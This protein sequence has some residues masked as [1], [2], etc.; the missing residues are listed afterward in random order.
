MATAV[1]FMHSS[2][3]SNQQVPSSTAP[4]LE[5][6]C[7]FT[8]DLRRKQKRWQDG[9][10][11]YHTFNKR[12]MVY[13]DRGN[14]VGDTHWRE[15][16]DFD[17]GE[18]VELE[19][20]GTI[21]QVAECT[22]SRDQDLSELIDKRVREKT[23]RQAAAVARRPPTVEATTPHAAVPHF[24]LR[25]KPLHHLIGTPTGHHGRA[26]ISTESPYEE[27][28]K[29]VDSPQNDGARPGKRR[30]R[31]IS[32]PSKNGYAQSL[33]G[34]TLTLSGVPAS[35]PPA[36]N[37]PS[38]KTSPILIDSQ[39]LPSS[40][41]SHHDDSIDFVPKPSRTKNLSALA[42]AQADAPRAMPSNFRAP[43]TTLARSTVRITCPQSSTSSAVARDERQIST[44]FSRQTGEH[45]SVELG[46]RDLEAN[47]P[48][49][50][51]AALQS[52]DINKP[53]SALGHGPL[54]RSRDLNT[55]PKPK[56]MI[57]NLDVNRE[58]QG[59]LRDD[60]INKPRTE[61]R[62]RP[63]KKRGLLM[64]SENLDTSN[65]S[66]SKTTK[67]RTKHQNQSTLSENTTIEDP[68]NDS[69]HKSDPVYVDVRESDSSRQKKRGA[70]RLKEDTERKRRGISNI[71]LHCTEDEED[72]DA[73]V[74]ETTEKT[75]GKT[76]PSRKK[77][78]SAE[79][80]I[81]P[82]PAVGGCEDKLGMSDDDEF[83]LPNDAP[84]PRLAH[85]GRK[86]IRSK[87]VIGFFFDEEPDH[88][89]T[90]GGG[91][92][93]QDPI[94]NTNPLPGQPS[95]TK[96]ATPEPN[97][98]DIIA[99]SGVQVAKGQQPQG[100]ATAMESRIADVDI[101]SGPAED[102]DDPIA[103]RVEEK[104]RL[105]QK[106]SDCASIRINPK[107]DVQAQAP[108]GVSTTRQ[109]RQPRTGIVANP[110]TRGKKAAKASDAAGQTPQC[111]LPSES[112][113]GKVPISVGHRDNGEAPGLETRRRELNIAPLPGFAR[114]NGGPWSRE[115]HDLFEF[116]C[117]LKDVHK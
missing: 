24:Q 111:P 2:S 86:S 40:N 78:A 11:K 80:S 84:A 103:L 110:A 26:L 4:V 3:P 37:K 15:D 96:L 1:Q 41:P 107:A 65:S 20:G 102:A 50:L 117:P 18:E 85:L 35:T 79:S 89:N 36:R 91:G 33:F 22:G 99:T 12:I 60:H 30:K 116:A 114:A 66:R 81:D 106:Q 113:T 49:L 101:N 83:H 94:N 21:V 104:P 93:R 77:T 88:P 43:E 97:R 58:R 64:V 25:H 57:E 45:A 115:A 55:D 51:T 19:R 42:K 73:A 108:K 109:R 46:L 44:I 100:R 23:E 63:R 9:R 34:A 31:D 90:G 69:L 7:L 56:S 72:E 13:D 17:E 68:N 67:S 71:D 29:L 27:R 47:K 52:K 8:R 112:I 92:D 54:A 10:L 32:P 75:R 38:T 70:G 82:D 16:N 61:L 5:F 28:R 95:P 105:S 6:V 39:S 74:A 53:L 62:I 14:F 87:E 48:N 59:L 76:R 98:I